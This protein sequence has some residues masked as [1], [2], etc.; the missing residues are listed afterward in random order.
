MTRAGSWAVLLVALSAIGVSS[1]TAG[2][3][4]DVGGSGTGCP[5]R[6]VCSN[7]TVRQGFVAA[8]SVVALV[9][10]GLGVAP[11][12]PTRGQSAVL[13]GVDAQSGRQ[14]WRSVIGGDDGANIFISSVSHNV[15]TVLRTDC[16]D[17]STHAVPGNYSLQAYDTSS[18]HRLW[19]ESDAAVDTMYG[20][21]DHATAKVIPVAKRDGT[22][23]GVELRSGRVRWSRRDARS[24]PDGTE[25]LR[26]AGEGTIGGVYVQSNR[27][28]SAIARARP[29]IEARGLRDDRRRWRHAFDTSIF[30]ALA[31]N[32]AE[33]V[34]LTTTVDPA[35]VGT[36]TVSATL[37]A[38]F[39]S[40]AD[41]TTIR[42]LDL[43]AWPGPLVP[44][45]ALTPTTL[46][47][48]DNANAGII[49]GYDITTGALR[50]ETTGN[51]AFTVEEVVGRTSIPGTAIAAID[52][53]TGAPL[54]E[55]DARF[56]RPNGPHRVVLSDLDPYS[57]EGTITSVHA[58]TGEAIWSRDRQPLDFGGTSRRN[59]VIANPGCPIGDAA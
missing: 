53:L 1:A 47:V 14:Q 30:P 31:A 5:G 21:G 43:G 46:V 37:R 36:P 58:R 54:W 7:R 18:G 50:W 2:T 40:P 3:S 39:L 15:A 33:F 42:T 6:V 41:G 56:A 55:H 38:E 22:L 59:A 16:D 28:A 29:T 57:G 49:R 23:E 8:V 24:L 32:G 19:A 13:I 17:D 27:H 34:A 10:V 44:Q 20:F 35:T 9:G 12:R 26:P 48:G 25:G 11:A 51:I 52:A 45:A 4:A